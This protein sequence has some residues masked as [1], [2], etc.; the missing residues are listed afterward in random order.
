MV[1]DGTLVASGHEQN[2]LDPVGDQ[3]FHHVLHDR[4][5]RNR[6]HFLGLRLGSRQQAG[7]QTRDR[8]NGALN[9]ILNIPTQE[10]YIGQR[11]SEWRISSNNSPPFASASRAWTAST[12]MPARRRVHSSA[13]TGSSSRNCSPAKSS[14]RPSGSTSKPRSFGNATAATAASS[15]AI[16]PNS[17]KTC[18]TRFPAAPSLAST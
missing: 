10:C 16:L 14:P 4:F 15:S 6:Q 17:P 18:S 12:L 8:N 9:H 2:L 7:P 13:R 11:K 5:A 1:L 3:F